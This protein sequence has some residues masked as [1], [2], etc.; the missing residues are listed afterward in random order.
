M[1]CFRFGL[2]IDIDCCWS[3]IGRCRFFGVCCQFMLADVDGCWLLLVGGCWS[4]VVVGSHRL[5]SV[6][7]GCCWLL[8]VGFIFG[9]YMRSPNGVRCLLLLVVFICCCFVVV[10]AGCC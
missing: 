5:S 3:V 10:D 2:L 6:G 9:C 8:L 4:L 7:M 1:V